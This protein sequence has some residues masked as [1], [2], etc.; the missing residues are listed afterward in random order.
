MYSVGIIGFELY[1]PFQTN[2]E[3]MHNIM[4]LRRGEISETFQYK[5]PVEVRSVFVFFSF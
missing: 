5:W 2:M 1:C 3:R 4:E